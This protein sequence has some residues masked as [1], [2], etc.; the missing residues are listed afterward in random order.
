M[1]EYPWQVGMVTAGH[2][3]VWCGGSLISNQWILTAAHCT[4]DKSPSDIEVLLGEHD[5]HNSSE[6]SVFRMT[7]AHIEDHPK[8]NSSTLNYDFSLLKIKETVDFMTLRH[9]RPIC[10]PR[11]AIDD[12]KNF[13]A[14]VTGWGRLGSTSSGSSVLMEVQM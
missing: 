9:I 7:I 2:S 13:V 1:N 14:T 6:T 10:L 11:E 3:M 8:Y 4:Q 12:Y 5:L